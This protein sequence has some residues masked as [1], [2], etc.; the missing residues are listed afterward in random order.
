VTR[1]DLCLRLFNLL[2]SGSRRRFGG[3]GR[4]RR[5]P[6]RRAPRLSRDHL[7]D[8]QPSVLVGARSQ[9]CLVGET[10][11]VVLHVLIA[12]E[13]VLA[14]LE[15]DLGQARLELEVG[16]EEREL[17]SQASELRDLGDP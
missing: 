5:S 16:G 4:R 3:R 2:L 9:K 10:G 1:L 13:R 7:V 11:E 8:R 12:H 6:A 17:G 14:E 15:H